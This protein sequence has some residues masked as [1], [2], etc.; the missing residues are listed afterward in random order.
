MPVATSNHHNTQNELVDAFKK[1]DPLVLESFYA[2]NYSK[3]EAYIIQNNGDVE[4]AKDIFQEAFVAVWQ[5]IKLDKFVPHNATALSG[6]IYQ[7]ARNKWIDYLRSAY[8]KNTL[9][10]DSMP[11]VKEPVPEATAE[12]E[13]QLQKMKTHFANLGATC[14]DVLL[15]FYYQKES[16]RNIASSLGWTEA[17]AR[18]NKYRCLQQLKG[19]MKSTS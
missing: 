4:K 18:N 14:K 19:L 1:N 11:L 8:K 6:Y 3:V 10:T 17:T 15:R 7:I 12:Q 9:H 5:N 13:E 2:G 16:L